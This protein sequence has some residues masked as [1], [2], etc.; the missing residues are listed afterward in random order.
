[1]Q[2]RWYEKNV[3]VFLSLSWLFSV[4][5]KKKIKQLQ[6]TVPSRAVTNKVGFGNNALVKYILRHFKQLYHIFLCKKIKY[7]SKQRSQI[8]VFRT[9]S[10]ILYIYTWLWNDRLL[11]ILLASSISLPS[12]LTPSKTLLLAPT[13]FPGGS[14]P[15][16][17]WA[18]GRILERGTRGLQTRSSALGFPMWG[19]CV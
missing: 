14:A 16:G 15:D 7:A 6:N 17:R 2:G 12:A 5:G 9:V 19:I 18:R 1:M 13:H 8:Q 11:V 4:L 10:T 3:F